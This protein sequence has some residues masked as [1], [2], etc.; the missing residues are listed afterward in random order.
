MAYTGAWSR[1]ASMSTPMWTGS[2]GSSKLPRTG[3]MEVVG[4]NGQPP[5]AGLAPKQRASTLCSVNAGFCAGPGAGSGDPVLVE[6]GGGEVGAGSVA[7]S[8]AGGVVA[9]GAGALRCE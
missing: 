7:G 3:W 2:R 5:G 4:A 1:G 8:V 9:A 6:A